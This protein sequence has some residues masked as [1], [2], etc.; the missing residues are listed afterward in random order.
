MRSTA[1]SP[2]IYCHPLTASIQW[3]DKLLNNFLR[4][5]NRVIY[6]CF[7]Y[8]SAIK[9]QGQ[10]IICIRLFYSFNILPF[11]TS[12]SLHFDYLTYVL[13]SNFLN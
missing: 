10:K 7:L 11:N 2:G 6:A 1:R 12:Q 4:L 8:L 13:K 5:F 3:L 9:I